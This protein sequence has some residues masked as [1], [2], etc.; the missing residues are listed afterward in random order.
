MGFKLPNM[1][2]GTLI[3]N[4]IIEQQIK[5]AKEKADIKKQHRHDF[6]IATYGIV[7]GFASGIISSLIVL[8]IQGLL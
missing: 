4:G 1:A 5:E 2:K 7:G 8:Y 6:F 3:P